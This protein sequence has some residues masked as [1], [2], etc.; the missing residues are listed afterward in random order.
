MLQVPAGTAYDGRLYTWFVAFYGRVT[1]FLNNRGGT[2]APRLVSL[3]SQYYHPKMTG[4]F[5]FLEEYSDGK[6][7]RM[8]FGGEGSI[9]IELDGRPDGTASVAVTVVAT[10][11]F[12]SFEIN[13]TGTWEDTFARLPPHDFLYRTYRIDT[14][15]GKVRIE[16]SLEPGSR[17]WIQATK[18]VFVLPGGKSI[19]LAYEDAP[20]QVARLSQE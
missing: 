19:A 17:S 12:P 16:E 13:G 4:G 15:Q 11:D 10:G 5:K 7:G 14:P 3:S 6:Q 8:Q 18:W 9:A 20:L 1:A 2:P